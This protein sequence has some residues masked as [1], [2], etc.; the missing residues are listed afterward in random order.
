MEHLDLCVMFNNEAIYKMCR[1]ILDIEGPSY[2]NIN[3]LIAQVVSN[4]TVSLRFNGG[5]LNSN[6]CE[7]GT[8]L[9]PYR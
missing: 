6:L 7:F 4:T 1:L 9:V 3:R 5:G 2:I 8:N